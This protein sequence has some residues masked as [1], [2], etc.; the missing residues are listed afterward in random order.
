M[1]WL[2][3]HVKSEVE[4]LGLLCA[5]ESLMIDLL[6]YQNSR[7]ATISKSS[8]PLSL[9]VLGGTPSPAARKGGAV[10]VLTDPLNISLAIFSFPHPAPRAF[11]VLADA[12]KNFPPHGP[13][14]HF[15]KQT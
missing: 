4:I 14:A 1:P 6:S 8:C 11:N 5:S 15:A 7:I 10:D 12:E 2:A 9:C 13:N 3:L